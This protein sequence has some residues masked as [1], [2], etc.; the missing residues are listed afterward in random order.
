MLGIDNNWQCSNEPYCFT[1]VDDDKLKLL[2][3][4][5]DKVLEI[6]ALAKIMTNRMLYD[7]NFGLMEYNNWCVDSSLGRNNR[8]KALWAILQAQGDID[9]FD[10]TEDKFEEMISEVLQ[11]VEDPNS[12]KKVW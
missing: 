6:V 3:K 9:F 10:T 5:E 12:Y 8:S 11:H 1:R 2:E 7:Q 4:E